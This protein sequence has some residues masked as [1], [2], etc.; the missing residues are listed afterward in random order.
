MRDGRAGED[1][2]AALDVEA[3]R[4]VQERQDAVRQAQERGIAHALLERVHPGLVRVELVGQEHDLPD[5][6]EVRVRRRVPAHAV[7]DVRVVDGA[8]D[9]E[10]GGPHGA[11]QQE[12]HVA[13]DRGDGQA[14][15]VRLLDQPWAGDV[16]CDVVGGGGELGEVRV[17]AV[18]LAEGARDRAD[19]ADVRAEAG[20]Q[21]VEPGLERGWEL[22]GHA[23]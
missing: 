14:E 10:P 16:A 23:A 21:R 17:D 11:V 15:A 9:R 5:R 19:A 4:A 22:D 1:E 20:R 8:I 7:E 3:Q 18:R 6:R 2:L 13:L 12:G